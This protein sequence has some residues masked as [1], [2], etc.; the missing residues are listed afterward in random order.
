M[1]GDVT[2]IVR[3]NVADQQSLVTRLCERQDSRD[4]WQAVIDKRLVEWGRD[5]SGLEDDGITPPSPEAV[6]QAG[7]LALTWRDEGVAHPLRVAPTGDG[8]IVFERWEGG[9]FQSIE[10]QANGTIELATFR[11]SRLLSRRR[12]P[13]TSPR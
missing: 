4:A 7:Q 13:L 8:G 2:P 5:P 12:L 1:S 9:L 11:N 6:Y 10:I 3:T